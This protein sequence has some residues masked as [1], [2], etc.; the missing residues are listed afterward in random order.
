[1]GIVNKAA[2]LLIMVFL[3]GSCMSETAKKA[4]NEFDIPDSLVS[5]DTTRGEQALD[6]TKDMVDH[7]VEN[8]GSP[9]E[10]IAMLK[11]LGI[12]F[13]STLLADNDKSDSFNSSYSQAA[14]LGI[15]GADLGY[16]NFYGKTSLVL[17][18]IS[19]VKG[20]ADELKVGQFFDYGTLKRLANNNENVDSLIFISRKSMNRI[21]QYLRKTQRS[22]ISAAIVT[23]VWIE[24]MHYLTQFYKLNK[25]SRLKEAIGDQKT[26]LAQLLKVLKSYNYHPE[27]ASL[28]K[29]M[30][31]L[32][33]GYKGVTTTIESGEPEYKEVNGVYTVIQHDRT[34]INISS[35]QISDIT[36]RTQKIRSKLLGE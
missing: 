3:L 8:M 11:S 15:Y 27:I 2:C 14:A 29:D 12:P 7:M 16:L 28:E 25:K 26:L 23:G 5:A 18:Y 9:I 24:G 19:T 34:V 13:N 35:Q 17:S 21:D 33:E 20:L 4:K 36:A 22:S 6:E 1:M 32:Y 31:Y 10:T 30:M